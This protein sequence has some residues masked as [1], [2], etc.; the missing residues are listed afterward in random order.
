MF[1]ASRFLLYV[2]ISAVVW[3]A[4]VPLYAELFTWTEHISGI[5]WIYLPHGLRMILVLLFGVAGAV[6][7]SIGAHILRFTELDGIDFN[8]ALHVPFAFIPGLAAYFAVVL[9]V[10]NWP[11]KSLSFQSGAG[12]SGIDGRQLLLVAFASGLLNSGGHC[13]VRYLIE[14]DAE[15]LLINNFVSM[16]VGDVLGAVLLLYALK[17]IFWLIERRKLDRER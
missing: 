16:F 15:S 8:S 2:T 5:N 11:G 13:L 3:C 6:G 14:G 7:F 1:R 12:M 10:K 17:G 9:I 4:F